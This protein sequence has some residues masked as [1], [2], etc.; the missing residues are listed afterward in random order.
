MDPG[1]TEKDTWYKDLRA[2]C[3]SVI[4]FESDEKMKNMGK[5][6]QGSSQTQ[7]LSKVTG[8]PAEISRSPAPSSQPQSP[9]RPFSQ[10]KRASSSNSRS[11]S[12][13][14]RSKLVVREPQETMDHHDG[15]EVP[16]EQ[17][18]VGE[19]NQPSQSPSGLGMSP[20]FFH[21]SWPRCMASTSALDSCQLIS[22]SPPFLTHAYPPTEANNPI[23]IPSASPSPLGIGYFEVSEADR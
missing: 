12:P 16:R 13:S 8:T 19:N 21:S 6:K 4:K 2:T 15:Y 22:A 20:H 11:L 5:G 1:F 18:R 14:K 7:P 3:D 23:Y 9:L 10:P 17:G